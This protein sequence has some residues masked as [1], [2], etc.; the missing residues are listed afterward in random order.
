MHCYVCLAEDD[1]L[2]RDTCA[3]RSAVVHA[4]CLRDWIKTSHSTQCAMC[5]EPYVGVVVVRPQRTFVAVHRVLSMATLTTLL[6]L[7]F[8]VISR[9]RRQGCIFCD[10]NDGILFCLA[11]WMYALLS[12]RTRPAPDDRAIV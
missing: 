4:E 8:L 10:M 1:E 3:C 6:W 12:L 7:A 2:L 5:G 9:R 11:V